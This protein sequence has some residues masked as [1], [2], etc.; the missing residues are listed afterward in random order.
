MVLLRK[1]GKR[2][3]HKKK[4]PPHCWRSGTGKAGTSLG[5]RQF[6]CQFYHRERPYIKVLIGGQRKRPPS[7][8]LSKNHR[9]DRAGSTAA[10]PPR[11]SAA[12]SHSQ[13]QQRRLFPSRQS[14]GAGH[15][16]VRSMRHRA[17]QILAAAKAIER[18]DETVEG[19]VSM[20][21]VFECHND[22]A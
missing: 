10:D 16:C 6:L 15:L 19:Q 14:A 7:P 13:Q 11:T 22:Q 4:C 1:E 20:D 9:L 12:H 8:G 21:G 2:I 18:D 3:D 17:G 5:K